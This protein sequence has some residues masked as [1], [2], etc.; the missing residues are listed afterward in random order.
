VTRKRLSAEIRILVGILL[1]KEKLP[2]EKVQ[3]HRKKEKVTKG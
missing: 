3:T 2:M 1:R